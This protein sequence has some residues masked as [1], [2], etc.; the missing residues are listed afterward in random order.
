MKKLFAILLS[1][2]M[3]LSVFPMTALADEV[4]LT[5]DEVN[6]V[7][8]ADLDFSAYDSII[9][10]IHFIDNSMYTEESI[11]AM[12][13]TV[14]DK[15]Y[16]STQAD[17]DSAVKRI[18]EAYSNL[19]KKTYSVEF[20]TVDSEDNITNE[21]FSYSHG[22]MA[23]FAVEDTDE[24][25][26]KWVITRGDNDTK[27]DATSD[28]VSLVITEDVV[29]T[30]YTTIAPE[31]AE[32]TQRVLFL[33]ANGTPV[34]VVYTTDVNNVAMPAAPAL[35]FY[36]FDEW[37]KL[38]DT[39][40]QAH[41]TMSVECGDN[42]HVFTVTV[43]N[44][45]CESVGYLIFRCPCGEGFRT[46]YVKPTGHSFDDDIELCLNGCGMVNPNF[47]VEESASGDVEPT[48]PAEPTKPSKEPYVNGVD[49]GGYNTYVLM[50]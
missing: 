43:I 40:Y 5:Y 13:D 25:I 16:L 12:L 46:D 27:L 34:S 37:V 4:E 17:V 45:G 7:A 8:T 32:Q 11:E 41:Y 9:T 3:V 50:P 26:Y 20:F 1:A 19:Q 49:E 33:A 18:A 22:D 35:P 15:D 47:D 42:N 39:T 6:D 31:V 44:P 48:Q 38:D 29:I 14:V 21:K 10:L 28:V 2:V 23:E 36:A 30:A 24:V